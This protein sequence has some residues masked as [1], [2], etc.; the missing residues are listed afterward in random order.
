MSKFIC[1]Q[2]VGNFSSLGFCSY[3][4]INDKQPENWVEDCS[5]LTFEAD[6]HSGKIV[7][8]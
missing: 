7:S 6:M 1:L 8:S 4:K 2:K 3:Q 5:L